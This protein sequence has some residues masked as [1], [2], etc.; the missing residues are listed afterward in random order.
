MSLYLWAFL[1]LD[2]VMP[3]YKGTLRMRTPDVIEAIS[4]T[5]GV[6]LSSKVAVGAASSAIRGSAPTV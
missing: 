1:F 4:D 6:T 2:V 5:V 3:Q